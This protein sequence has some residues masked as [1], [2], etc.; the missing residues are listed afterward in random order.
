MA[1]DRKALFGGVFLVILI[2]FGALVS[3]KM[4]A[5]DG[6]RA[7]PDFAITT[8]DGET[9]QLADFAGRPVML[10][11]WATSCVSCV[12]EIPDLVALHERFSPQGFEIIAVALSYDNERHVRALRDNRNIPYIVAFDTDDVA[13]N[14]YG[15]VRLTPTTFLI[16]PEGRIAYQKLGDPDFDRIRG[17]LDRW[18]S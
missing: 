1:V 15:R 9:I 3:W 11:F 18:T 13:S 16:S 17:L 4:L 7:A 5:G 10:S 12:R 14:A 8:L 2:A 6:A